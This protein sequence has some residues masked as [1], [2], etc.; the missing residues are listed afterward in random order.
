[1]L[2]AGSLNHAM[3]G[4]AE[5]SSFVG[6]ETRLAID[7]KANA[8]FRKILHRLVHTVHRKIED[9]EGRRG[10]IGLGLNE[11][12]GAACEVQFQQAI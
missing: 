2:P 1:M 8:V 7:L 5:N 6:F 11:N 12:R 9:R 10:M 4:A 3:T